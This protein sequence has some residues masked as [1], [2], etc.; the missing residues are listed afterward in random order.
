LTPDLKLIKFNIELTQEQLGLQHKISSDIANIG[1]KK[2]RNIRKTKPCLPAGRFK[3]Q[4]QRT[5]NPNIVP[6]IQKQRKNRFLSFD[7]LSKQLKQ[8]SINNIPD[9]QQEQINHPDWPKHLFAY[10][11]KY[12]GS[13]SCKPLFG[14]NHRKR[15]DFLS[16]EE[17]KKEVQKSGITKRKQYEKIQRKHPLWPSSPEIVYRGK[18]WIDFRNLL[19]NS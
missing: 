11:K 19:L 5:D 12:T 6:T 1:I 17:L 8:Y 16:L 14:I 10:C 3:M 4:E 18:G 9:Y 13:T 15:K 2:F 7:E